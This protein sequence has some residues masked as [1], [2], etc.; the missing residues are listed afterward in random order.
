MFFN[1]QTDKQK[2]KYIESLQLIGS[3]SLLYSESKI[4]YLY[5]RVAEKLFCQA[6]E[7]KDLS[8]IGVSAD[9]K[10][11]DIGIGLKTFLAKNNNT[12]Q[13]VA[14]FNSEMEGYANLNNTRLVQKISKLRNARIRLTEDNH[15]INKS[16]YHC[17]L[18]V[19]GEF[20]IFETSMNKINICNIQNIKRKKNT[21]FFRDDLDEYSFSLSKSTLFKRF[22]S[23]KPVLILDR[24]K[25]DIL[26]DPLSN[27]KKCLSNNVEF[28][29]D[30]RVKQTIYLPLYGDNGEVQKR[31]ALNQWNAKGRRRGESEVYIAIPQLIHNT[32]HDFFPSR[33]TSFVLQL[34]NGNKLNCKVCQDNSKALMSD[35]N[36][37]LGEWILRNVL[38]LKSGKLLTYKHLKNLD[39]DS[40]RIDKINDLEFEINFSQIDSYEKFKQNI[41]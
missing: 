2:R 16:I 36:K 6:F 18:R 37:A 11:D 7:A 8:R 3:L 13:K 24:F 10:K 27:L 25:V 12:F 39:V 4:P 1:Q 20:K 14:E 40:V 22:V 26:K 33:G 21:I 30:T 23:D 32:F 15:A 41:I 28:L 9:A 5:Y 19:E 31:S 38:G 34:P 35:P 29:T 17:V